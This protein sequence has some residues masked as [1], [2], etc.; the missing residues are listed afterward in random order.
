MAVDMRVYDGIVEQALDMSRTYREEERTEKELSTLLAELKV[1]MPPEKLKALGRYVSL[2][3][4]RD[5]DQMFNTFSPGASS[6]V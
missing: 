6:G 3:K 5:R 1:E 2:A 4:S